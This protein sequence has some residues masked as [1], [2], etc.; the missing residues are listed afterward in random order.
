MTGYPIGLRIERGL[1][2][3]VSFL[4]NMLWVPFFAPFLSLLIKRGREISLLLSIVTVQVLYSVYVGGDAWEWWGGANRFICVAMPAFF[5][6][7][8]IGL[9][10]MVE[11]MSRAAEKEVLGNTKLLVPYVGVALLCLVLFNT[12]HGPSALK[13]WLLLDK[14]FHWTDNKNMVLRARLVED[15]TMNTAT[16]AVTWAGIIPY[17]TE[18][19]V[20]DLLGKTNAKI[21]HGEVAKRPPAAEYDE[22]LPGHMKWDYEY[23]IGQLEPDLIVQIWGSARQAAK[24]LE[25]DYLVTRLGPFVFSFRKDSRNIYW[26]RLRSVLGPPKQ[27]QP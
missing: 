14:P 4:N 16:I 8:S 20:V 25:T 5:V 17:F 15:F 12:I 18:R 10:S 24:W 26:N 22:F 3:F 2:V 23:S 1:E 19:P 6:A 9:A 7:F 11:K 13:E 21:A 27:G